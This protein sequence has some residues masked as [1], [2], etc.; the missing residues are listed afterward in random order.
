MPVD[1][2]ERPLSIKVSGITCTPHKNRRLWNH[3]VCPVYR[4]SLPP[5]NDEI[6]KKFT[7]SVEMKYC[8]KQYP[9]SWPNTWCLEIQVRE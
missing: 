7:E 9:A 4:A 2:R 1:F 5:L 8:I 6:E 3:Q